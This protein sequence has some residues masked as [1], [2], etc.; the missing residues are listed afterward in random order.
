MTRSLD[1]TGP[2]IFYSA[3]ALSCSNDHPVSIQNCMKSF[4]W[5]PERVS[6]KLSWSLAVNPKP[7]GVRLK[8][9]L[10]MLR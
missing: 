6:S 7:D 1:D 8:T 9:W 2:L 5:L 10:C 4:G 3:P